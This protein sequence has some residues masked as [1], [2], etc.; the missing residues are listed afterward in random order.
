MYAGEVG[1]THRVGRVGVVLKSAVGR[2]RLKLIDDKRCCAER[3]NPAHSD[4][5]WRRGEP[6]YPIGRGVFDLPNIS[7]NDMFK[8]R[9]LAL[10]ALNRT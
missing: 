1:R 8:A 4:D 3:R 2:L 5:L 10:R 6:V 9:Y 7:S